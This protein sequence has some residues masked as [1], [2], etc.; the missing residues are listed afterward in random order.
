MNELFLD[1]ILETVVLAH[2]S[3]ETLDRVLKK[4]SLSLEGDLLPRL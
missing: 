3:N 4:D 1:L 2:E